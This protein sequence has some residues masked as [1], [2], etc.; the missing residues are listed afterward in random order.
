MQ[1]NFNTYSFSCLLLDL[2]NHKQL[3][4]STMIV[5]KL[6]KNRNPTQ[7]GH[8]DNTCELSPQL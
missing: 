1:I 3:I 4:M 2:I 6:V 5:M 8:D 7:V